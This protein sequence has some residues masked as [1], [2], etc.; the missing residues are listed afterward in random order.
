MT[1]DFITVYGLLSLKDG[2]MTIQEIRERLEDRNLSEVARRSGIN[3]QTLF[4]LMK[5][6]V[7]YLSH[8]NHVAI[9]DYL[10]AN[11]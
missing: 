2:A 9:E 1:E 5:D 7:D 11:K 3:P 6:K 4:R 8:R 10:E